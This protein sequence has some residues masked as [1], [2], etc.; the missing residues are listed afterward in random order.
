MSNKPEPPKVKLVTEV[1][2]IFQSLINARRNI[3]SIIPQIATTQ[4]MVSGK[5]AWVRWHMVMSPN[6]IRRILL[7]KLDDYP[8]SDVTKNLLGPAIGNSMFI[9]EGA[10]WRWQR[11]AA[12]PVFSAR[13]IANL[14]PVMS[15]S[16]DATVARLAAGN[17]EYDLY[18]EMIQATFD[19]I[20]NVTFSG[21]GTLDSNE[22]QTAIDAYIEQVAKISLFDVIGLPTWIP[23]PSRIF[24]PN[25]LKRTK[26]V[27]DNAIVDRR[28]N[29]AKTIP[30]LL[31]L[32]MAGADPETKRQMNAD[33]LRDNLLTFIVAGHETTALT[34]SWA[35][36]LCAFDPEVQEK[37]R[38][39]ARSVLDGRTATANDCADLIYTKQVINETLRLYP[40]AALISRTAQ[41]DDTLCDRAVR[42]G[43]TV[44]IPIYALHRNHD[45]W[46]NPDQ[47]NPER[48]V[49]GGDF[50][51]YAFLP[52]GD[53]PRVCI[54]AQFAMAEA[55]IILS[56]LMNNFAFD[57]IPD[58]SP[59]DPVMVLT[60]RPMGGIRL[61]VRKL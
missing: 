39:E 37:L 47:F 23:R 17:G 32:L 42:S 3:L 45:L 57:L 16:A 18:Q 30:D 38:A 40:P 6:A 15:A 2:G 28:E 53:G 29:G 10:H 46:P 58:T 21:S 24:Q 25:T 54:G 60:L 51:R 9:A 44:M 41:A 31:D 7:E 48:F 50:E 11:R 33:E 52:F 19:V 22:V 13:N 12:A 26:A 49:D 1:W 35:L 59:P 20:S 36:Y 34:L 4:P 14:A 61:N 55:Q 43:D 8:K 56:T 5:L 27:A